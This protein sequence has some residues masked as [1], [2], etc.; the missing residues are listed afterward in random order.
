MLRTTAELREIVEAVAIRSTD[1]F[2]VCGETF[3][4]P[5]GDDKIEVL[6]LHLTNVLYQRMYC[7]PERN[8]SRPEADHREARVFVDD[9]SRANSGSGT[10][11]PGWVV[12]EI[13]E[14]GTLVV[15]KQRGDLTLWARSEQFRSTDSPAVRGSVGRLRL[16]KELRGML[17]GYYMVLGNADQRGDDDGAPVATVRFYWHLT[18]PAAP[19]WI[20]ELTRRFN[21]A[22]VAFHA[23]VQSDPNAYYRADA[24]VLYVA[25][26]ELSA[27][28]NLLPDLHA[29]ISTQLRSSTPMF[30]KYLARGLATAE[31][32]GD[33]RSFGQHRCRL[34]AEGLVRAFAAGSTDSDHL[35]GAVIERFTKEGLRV[36][37]PWLNAGSLERFAWPTRRPRTQRSSVA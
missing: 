3:D 35:L 30:T 17:P 37:R 4:V 36:T 21:A 26:D 2:S 13:E 25:H 32:P 34:V 7:R 10:W 6:T 27:V 22:R 5:T 8:R 11:E 14:D 9:L 23:K 16:G 33:G 19:L 24:G 18:A 15:H 20:S 29:T 1:N 31:D 12:N 28:V